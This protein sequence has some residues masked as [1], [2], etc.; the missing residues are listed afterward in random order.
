M[1]L[2]SHRTP[3][4]DRVK[5]LHHGGIEVVIGAPE[6]HREAIARSRSEE[7]HID[8]AACDAHVAVVVGAA[9][10]DVTPV[11]TEDEGECDLVPSGPSRWAVEHR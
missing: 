10:A 5:A 8:R 6:I 2:N 7:V 4:L 1:K 3:A 11:Q 9:A